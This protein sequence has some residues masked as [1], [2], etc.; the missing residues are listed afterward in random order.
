MTLQES[1]RLISGLSEAEIGEIWESCKE[2]RAKLEGCSRA[3]NFEP[4]EFRAPGWPR[5]YRCSYCGGVLDAQCVYW[6]NQ[7]LLDNQ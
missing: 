1:L 6:Y 3:H 5:N 4:F 2:N 7:G